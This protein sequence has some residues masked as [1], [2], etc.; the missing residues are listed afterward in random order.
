[1]T[2][3]PTRPILPM[4]MKPISSKHSKTY[5]ADDGRLNERECTYAIWV[6]R[7]IPTKYSGW[8]NLPPFYSCILVY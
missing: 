1:M 7:T 2:K 5:T 8:A 4:E 3:S 6:I